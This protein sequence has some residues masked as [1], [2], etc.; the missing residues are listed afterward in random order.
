MPS[1]F[2]AAD[3]LFIRQLLCDHGPRASTSCVNLFRSQARPPAERPPSGRG[4]ASPARTAFGAKSVPLNDIHGPALGGRG[5]ARVVRGRVEG[6]LGT[7]GLPAPRGFRLSGVCRRQHAERRSAPKP[8]A[9]HAPQNDRTHNG[10]RMRRL[11]PAN[12]TS[13]FR[14]S[15]VPTAVVMGARASS[16]S[17][18]S[19]LP[20]RF[21]SRRL[22][23]VWR[24][25]PRPPRPS[26]GERR[27]LWR[28]RG[29]RRGCKRDGARRESRSPRVGVMP[30]VD[31]IAGVVVDG[32]GRCRC[33][34]VEADGSGAT[35]GSR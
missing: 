9:G 26:K 2:R 34:K 27:R 22:G 14:Y 19:A 24:R 11:G 8:A 17:E 31:A 15:R 4:H 1:K 29:Y 16:R 23:G 25:T 12:R 30:T 7:S 18:Q 21:E 32:H 20:A 6:R 5:S 13:G 28:A 33:R 3:Q 35:R 10:P